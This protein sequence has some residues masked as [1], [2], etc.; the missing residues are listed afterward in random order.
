M[1]LFRAVFAWIFKYDQQVHL[2][3]TPADPCGFFASMKSNGDNYKGHRG[4]PIIELYEKLNDNV[5]NSSR[6]M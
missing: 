5:V 2:F 4:V 6:D 3:W 1:N